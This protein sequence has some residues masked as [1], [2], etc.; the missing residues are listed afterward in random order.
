[1]SVL[2]AVGISLFA[3]PASGNEA[4]A[5]DGCVFLIALASHQIGSHLASRMHDPSSRCFFSTVECIQVR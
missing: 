4:G 5:A 2:G 3:Q 1:M